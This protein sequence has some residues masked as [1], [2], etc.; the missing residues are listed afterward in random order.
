MGFGL[1]LHGRKRAVMIAAGCRSALRWVTVVLL[2]AAVGCSTEHAKQ[3]SA[4]TPRGGDSSAT[5]S[6]GVKNDAKAGVAH[7]DASRSAVAKNDAKAG[8]AHHDASRS[9]VAKNNAKAGVARHDASPAGPMN[10]VRLTQHG[11]IRFEPQ[12]SDIHV[13]QSLE[14][15]SE[16]KSTVTI[17]VSAGAFDKTEYVVGPG[18]MVSTGPARAAGSYSIG[19]EPAACQGAPLGARGSGPGVTVEG[20]TPHQ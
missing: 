14:W 4:D 8:V 9:A 13:G 1:E 19:S 3:K 17:H 6:T 2:I 11:C 12:W 5:A 16:L 20:A 10:R 7:H 15:Y 18:A